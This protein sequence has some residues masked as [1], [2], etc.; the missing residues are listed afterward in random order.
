MKRFKI[1][2]TSTSEDVLRRELDNDDQGTCRVCKADRTMVCDEVVHQRVAAAQY[3][4]AN[5]GK[6]AF[7]LQTPNTPWLDAVMQA[8]LQESTPTT[9]RVS[10]R[11]RVTMAALAKGESPEPLVD[12]AG[13]IQ[14]PSMPR[15][16]TRERQMTERT[17]RLANDPLVQDG[18]IPPPG[19]LEAVYNDEPIKQVSEAESKAMLDLN[20]VLS[21]G[22]AY[23]RDQLAKT[24]SPFEHAV[25]EALLPRSPLSSIALVLAQIDEIHQ[26]AGDPRATA[27]ALHAT[28]EIVRSLAQIIKDQQSAPEPDT[29]DLGW[30]RSVLG[31][32]VAIKEE[33]FQYVPEQLI[34]QVKDEFEKIKVDGT[35]GVYTKLEK[36]IKW[37]HQLAIVVEHLQ[38]RIKTLEG[39]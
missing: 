27:A 17:Q 35:T 19:Y 3:R 22:A 2:S 25:K 31:R 24:D 12:A 14:T 34:A 39:K 38:R 7:P 13:E 33:Q 15:V 9:A 10:T 16:S 30:G 1:L 28:L 37:A 36:A 21:E 23:I 5:M 32:T 6:D 26:F 18:I 8:D 4:G 20:P 11:E 29:T